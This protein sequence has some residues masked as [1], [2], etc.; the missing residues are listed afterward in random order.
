MNFGQ[1][2]KKTLKADEQNRPD[3]VEGRK[4]WRTTAQGTESRRYVFIDES[5]A[6]TTTMVAALGL[7]GARAPFVIDG[8][9]DT[10]VFRVYVEQVPELKPGDIVVLDNLRCHKDSYVQRLIE[11]A[12]AQVCFLPPYSPDFNPIE[13]MWSKIKAYLRKVCARTQEALYQSAIFESLPKKVPGSRF[14]IGSGRRFERSRDA[15]QAQALQSLTS[16]AL[17]QRKKGA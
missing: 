15:K 12:K 4:A 11:T 9:M 10:E 6:K 14:M 2:I 7:S 8:A 3:V 16:K 17:R 5:G 13:K 1:G